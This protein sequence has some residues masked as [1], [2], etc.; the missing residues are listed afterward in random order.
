MHYPEGPHSA[1][2]K[3]LEDVERECL[4]KLNKHGV[5]AYFNR[6]V[7]A[8]VPRMLLIGS[9]RA[10]SHQSGE[11]LTS[12]S[13]TGFG[14]R[15]REQFCKL[16]QRVAEGFEVMAGHSNLDLLQVSFPVRYQSWVESPH[17][18]LL[19][20]FLETMASRLSN[21]AECFKRKSADEYAVALLVA[22]VVEYTQVWHDEDTAALVRAFGGSTGTTEAM[23]MW[24]ERHTDLIE[25]VRRYCLRVESTQSKN[26]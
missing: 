25:S 9:L 22:H 7:T 12:E 13:L 5:Q 8:G 3:Y 4:T 2:S 14:P 16:L 6:L 17:L 23:R 26:P 1:Q 21:C 19:S 24:R 11:Q 10:L 18:T 20:D 15:D